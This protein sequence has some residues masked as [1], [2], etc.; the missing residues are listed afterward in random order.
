LTRAES[1]FVN[2]EIEFKKVHKIYKY[3]PLCVGGGMGGGEK[4]IDREI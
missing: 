2:I 4:T 1:I 3:F